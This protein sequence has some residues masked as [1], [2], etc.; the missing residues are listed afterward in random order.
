MEYIEEMAEN[1]EED[2]ERI[3][4]LFT[5]LSFLAENPFDLNT[6]DTEMFKRLP[7][8]SDLQI[9]EIIGYR[10]RH[11]NI[12][13]VYEL[14]NIASLDWPTIELLL[15]FVYAGDSESRQRVV[16]AKN[17]LKYGAN[18]IAVRYSRTLQEKQGYETLSDSILQQ[19]PN[20]K[21]LGEPFY[22][23]VRYSYTFDERIQAGLVAEKDAGEQK[24]VE[25]ND[26]WHKQLRQWKY[27]DN[28][29]SLQQWRQ[30][31]VKRYVEGRLSQDK[32]EKLKEVGI[33]K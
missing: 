26:M 6:A 20:R 11:G 5:D 22:H 9:D 21:Y 29:T 24:S 15:P 33:L 12:L 14:K 18:E 32:I 30:Q 7:F 25:S 27:N 17:L 19:Y 16:S 4:T 13:T 31:N 2:D 3:E 23:A 1:L 28:R 10:Q 8:L